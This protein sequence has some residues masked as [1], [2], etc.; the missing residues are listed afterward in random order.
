MSEVHR[1]NE[2]FGYGPKQCGT[3]CDDP[4]YCSSVPN[5]IFYKWSKMPGWTIQDV[6][7]AAIQANLIYW[8]RQTTMNDAGCHLAQ[9]VCDLSLPRSQTNIDF[10]SVVKAFLAGGVDISSCTEQVKRTCRNIVVRLFHF[11]F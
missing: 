3:T 1:Y 5:Y 9:A 7:R 11:I 6:G 4:H 2:Y 8:R 10:D